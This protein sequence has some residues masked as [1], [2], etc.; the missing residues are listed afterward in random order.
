MRSLV[1]L[2][3][4]LWLG[5]VLIAS[6]TVACIAGSIL[7]SDVNL[8]VDYGREYVFHTWWFI[9]MM[10]L[11]VVN[12]FLCSWRR[13]YI[14]LTLFRKRSYIENRAFYESAE[15]AYS[16]AWN[17]TLDPLLHALRKRYTIASVS[18]KT[19]YAQKGLTGRWGPTII[20]LGLVWTL[21]AGFC[22]LLADDFG[23]GVFDATVA[24]PEG[25][26]THSYF[27]RVDRTKPAAEDNLRENQMPFSVRALDFRADYYPN[28]SVPRHFSSILEVRDGTH[29]R[30][31]RVSMSSPLHY[32]GYKLT[33]NS[34]AESPTVLRGLFQVEDLNTGACEIVDVSAGDPVPLHHGMDNDIFLEVDR[35]EAGAEFRVLNLATGRVVQSGLVS[36]PIQDTSTP[37]DGALDTKLI[38]SRYAVVLGALFPNFRIDDAGQPTTEGDQFLNPAAMIMVYK[39]GEPNGHSWAFFD[40]KAQSIMGQPHPELEL[41]FVEHRRVPGSKAGGGLMDFEV[42]VEAH[43]KEPPK[44]LGSKWMRAGEPWELQVDDAVVSAPLSGSPVP[45]HPQG[46]E[47]SPS[48]AKGGAAS[49]PAAGGSTDT[50]Q[51]GSEPAHS[52]EALY[53]VSYMGQTRGHVTYLGL[54][55]DPSVGWLFAGCIVMILGAVLASTVPYREVWG[56]YDAEAGTLYLATSVRGTSHLAHREFRRFVKTLTPP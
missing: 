34:F 29:S 43:Q 1:R 14:A 46:S 2:L 13:S 4:S 38:G 42:L 45:L 53:R 20:H 22:R 19:C 31:A 23:W 5:I 26:S 50:I 3:S 48:P 6:L 36:S 16:L 32:R 55:K 28:S 18:G 35:L 27:T 11:L 25:A 47:S 49:L 12:L 10:G 21:I 51:T 37:H 9:G 7:S 30:I 39:H 33:Q 24:I 40:P 56:W 15:H 52:A 44:P 41:R 17:G 54:M 8:G